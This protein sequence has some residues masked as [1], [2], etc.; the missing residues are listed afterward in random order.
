MARFAKN[1]LGAHTA[2]LIWHDGDR[3]SEGLADAFRAS[4]TAIGGEIV[5]AMSYAGDTPEG[6]YT[7]Q[8]G[9]LKVTNPDV[10]FVPGFVP[11]VPY[12]A[13]GIRNAGIEATLLGG[14][15]WSMAGLLDLS[16]GALEGSYFSGHFSAEAALDPEIIKKHPHF[17]VA[18]HFVNAYQA[19]YGE[20][21]DALGANG[22]DALRLVLMAIARAKSTDPD[23]IRDELLNTRDYHGANIIEYFNDKRHAVKS[24]VLLSIVGDEIGYFD[25][26]EPPGHGQGGVSVEPDEHHEE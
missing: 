18:T 12:L 17:G 19:R 8:V 5:V 22:Y 3:Y 9:A 15:G 6:G 25:V 4:F 13:L 21:P 7:A 24:L 23:A 10:I 20:L 16:K 1:E 11:N 2:G 26:I 14:D